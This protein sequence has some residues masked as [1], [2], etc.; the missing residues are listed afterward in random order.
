[1]SLVNGALQIGR[2]AL[3]AYQSA[4]QVVGNNISNVATDG[5]T[6]QS[7][8]LTALS[9][10]LVSGGYQPGSGVALSGLQRNVDESL[11]DRYR[12]AIGDQ[13]SA[14]VSEDILGRIETSMNELTDS[15]LSTLLQ[16]F[17]NAF[18]DLQNDPTQATARTVVVTSA[19]SLATELARQRDEVLS[20]RDEINTEL[21]TTVDQA[22]ELSSEIADLNA[23]IAAL[24]CSGTGTANPLR[25]QRDGLLREL[26]ELVEVEVRE[27]PNGSIN[28][29]VGNEPLIQSGT[30]RGLTATLDTVNEQQK[31][32]VRFAD[33]NSPITVRGGKIGGLVEA[34]D[35][36]LVDYVGQLD[37]LAA[38]LISEVNKVH[39]QGQGL[40]GWE[41]V[42]GAFDVRDADATLNSAQAGL[43]LKPT[44]GSFTL[45]VNDQKTGT[46]TDYVITVDLDGSGTDDSLNSLVA[47]INSKV[48]DARAEATGDNRLRFV[49]DDGFDVTF[50][51]D[52]SNVLAALGV[53][54]FFTGSNAANLAVNSQIVSNTN[55]LAASTTGAAGDGTNAGN[56]AALGSEPV[57]GLG[58][59]SV[60]EFYNNIVTDVATKGSAA[61]A[62]SEATTSIS[63]ALASE[64][65][66]VSGVS[67][68]EETISMLALERAFQGA[69]R[70]AS[71]V[72]EMLQQLLALVG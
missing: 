38:G 39:S 7:A 24:E 8:V 17:F 70:Y 43:N 3:L 19:Q 2:N 58:N 69:S 28:V 9:G 13:A 32:T 68:D 16:N 60:T 10:G 29:Y 44:N 25:D 14:E 54:V 18:S 4:L 33:S 61:S 63:S 64:R 49:A 48:G 22:N 26:S 27:Q 12:V 57:A 56:L 23:Q 6:R 52:S 46:S 71:T 1:M 59:L 66:Q 15:D 67:L 30:N 42:T 40:D 65:E 5:Y 36:L 37:S 34:R 45:T 21:E 11:E 53:N 47:Q 35:E 62:R 55:L 50:S 41:D 72:D 31:I 51:E 20:L